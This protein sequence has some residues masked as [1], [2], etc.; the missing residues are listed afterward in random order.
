MSKLSPPKMY[1]HTGKLYTDFKTLW[2]PSM[3]AA[4][5][6]RYY[7]NMVLKFAATSSLSF[8]FFFF[9]FNDNY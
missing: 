5:F 4:T 3:Q 8:L 9:F 7:K 6:E 2:P 1:N